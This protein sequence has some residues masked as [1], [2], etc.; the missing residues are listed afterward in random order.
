V[1]T[2]TVYRCASAWL[3]DGHL[4]TDVDVAVADGRIVDI[5]P[6]EA[7]REAA[8]DDDR[9][10]A[11]PAAVEHLRGLVLPGLANAHSHAFH[12]ALRGRTHHDGGTFWTWRERMYAVA[13]RLDPDRL[14]ALARAT[15]AEMVLAGITAVGEFHYLHHAPDGRPYPDPT[16]MGAAVVTAAR[17]AGIRLT[18]LDTCYLAGGI[19]QPL[20]GA[21]R[22]FGDGDAAGWA[23]RAEA[24]ATRYAADDEVIVGAAVHSV[25]AVPPEAIAS[26]AAWAER[27]GAPLHVHVSEQPGE[28][29]AC[30][31]GYGCTPTQLLAAHGALGP[32]TTVV[33][34]THVGPD[35]IALLAASGSVVCLCP[36]TERDLGDGIGPARALHHAGL[37]LVLG[38]DGHA[39]IDPFE[40]AR[41]L[42]LDQRLVHLERGVLPLARLVDAL[43]VD[44][45]R[46]LGRDDAGRL[47]VGAR[48]DL[49]AVDLASV[50]TAGATDRDAIAAV[51]FAASA[52]DV[53]DVVVG[54]RRVVRDGVHVLGDVATL[55]AG[56]VAAV[57][58]ELPS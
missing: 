38:T 27:H 36:T 17:E 3:P 41:S 57:T 31:A 52:A 54:G 33:H 24:L 43:T 22:R 6:A 51:V 48:A 13:A 21:Q 25:R 14:H 7:A 23:R 39:R 19:G 16:T 53:T 34:A 9:E 47:E 40:E 42:E 1:S 45:H 15:F 8:A 46:S 2:R 18:L 4:A 50:R 44:G 30:Q 56:A 55:L 49:V 28:N 26:V 20:T 5:G 37:P 29:A 12:R 11:A 32:R 35:D 58:E 10:R